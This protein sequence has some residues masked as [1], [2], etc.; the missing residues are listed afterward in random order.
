MS[1]VFHNRI[2]RDDL[3]LGLVAA[4]GVY[5]GQAST[6]LAAALDE[7]VSAAAQQS[8]PA[9]E[10]RRQACRDLLRN[11]SYKPTGRAKPASEYLLKAAREGTFPRINALVDANNLVSLRERVPISVWDLD[12]ARASEF[13]FRLGE[14]NQSYAFNA[15]GQQLELEDLLCG[16]ALTSSGAVPIINPVKDSNLTKVS[17]STRRAAACIYFP[18]HPDDRERLPQLLHELSEW[19]CETAAEARCAVGVVEPR[20]SAVL[21]F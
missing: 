5:P 1:L 12:L 8:E 16:Y 20:A 21:S 6:R 19:F 17:P 4:H 9:F 3:A 13:E 14:A 7:A 2:E 11:R 15:A 18:W 10:R